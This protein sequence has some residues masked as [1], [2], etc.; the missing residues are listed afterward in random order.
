MSIKVHNVINS[1]VTDGTITRDFGEFIYRK[2]IEIESVYTS[3]PSNIAIR[4]MM[5]LL[6]R[7]MVQSKQMIEDSLTPIERMLLQLANISAI[8]EKQ[9]E[10][11]Q[12]QITKLFP[13]IIEL[14]VLECRNCKTKNAIYL[15]KCVNCGMQ[16]KP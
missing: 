11:Q 13:S 4:D 6:Q 15:T 9:Y 10:L 1:W 5:S 2:Y 16:L 7:N 3:N 8:Q 14:Y 12:R